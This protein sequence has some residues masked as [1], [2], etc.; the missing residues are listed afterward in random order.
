MKLLTRDTDYA[1]MALRFIAQSKK[2]KVTVTELVKELKIPK[3]F[4]RKILQILNQKKLLKSY[5]GQA[6]GFALAKAMKKIN[7]VE[8]IEIFQ[9]KIEFSKCIF[10]DYVCPQLA[11][12]KVKKKMDNIQKYVISELKSMTLE[13][14]IHKKKQ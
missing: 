12:C 13:S 6:G 10:K 3:P 14:L 1:V 7:L 11:T 9:G 2:E 4:L 8:V 5:K